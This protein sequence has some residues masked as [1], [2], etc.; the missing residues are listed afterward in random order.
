MPDRKEIDQTE[1]LRQMVEGLSKH[2]RDKTLAE[3]VN[4]TPEQRQQL[5]MDLYD[6][7][8]E[9]RNYLGKIL[10]ML[11]RL[12]NSDPID[13][14]A[15]FDLIHLGYS[16]LGILLSKD[17]IPFIELQFEEFFEKYPELKL[18]SDQKTDKGEQS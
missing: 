8:I 3:F 10:S 14:V 5:F 6:V 16:V 12:R 15:F 13:K 1:Y 2:W 17:T 18:R 9:T 7:K 11:S 4:A